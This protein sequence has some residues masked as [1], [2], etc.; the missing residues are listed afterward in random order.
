MQ[1]TQE[2]VQVLE[3]SRWINMAWDATP[4]VAQHPM[5][6]S[7]AAHTAISS[8]QENT[9]LPVVHNHNHRATLESCSHSGVYGHG[10]TVEAR[11]CM[12]AHNYKQVTG[13]IACCAANFTVNCTDTVK[14]TI[15]GRAAAP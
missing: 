7:T 5:H 15:H 1:T 10:S 12:R 3:R 4:K 11:V 2:M 6:S 14:R 9:Y 13:A 8:R